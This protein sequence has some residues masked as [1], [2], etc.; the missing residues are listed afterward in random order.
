M[1]CSRSQA[2]RWLPW[3]DTLWACPDLGS[4]AGPCST[5]PGGLS[6]A[7]EPTVRLWLLVCGPPRGVWMREGPGS[8]AGQSLRLPPHL[9]A[10]I[11][12]CAPGVLGTL[13]DAGRPVPLC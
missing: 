9:L 13:C 7:R 10:S 11:S 3:D 8:R 12:L 1:S 4:W 2:S 5:A 6:A